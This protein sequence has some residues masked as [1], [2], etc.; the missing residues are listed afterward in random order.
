[1]K[2]ELIVKMPFGLSTDDQIEKVVNFEKVRLASVLESLCLKGLV[3]YI[4][5]YNDEDW[6]I[7][8]NPK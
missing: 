7:H 6:R 1:M 2:A 3:V 4:R 8:S 5:I